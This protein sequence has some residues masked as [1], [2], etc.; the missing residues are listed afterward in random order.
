MDGVFLTVESPH[1]R[2]RHH[3]RDHRRWGRRRRRGR[4]R[5]NFHRRRYEAAVEVTD[6]HAPI[7]TRV[8]VARL[9][10]HERQ[11]ADIRREQNFLRLLGRNLNDALRRSIE[12]GVI[13]PR[14][15][16]RVSKRGTIPPM[17]KS[18]KCD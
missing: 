11:T 17:V 2:Y 1:D 3:I 16:Y 9:T 8:L 13:G 10:Q 15:G 18:Y 6:G 12:A 5:S 14:P 4:W 7:R